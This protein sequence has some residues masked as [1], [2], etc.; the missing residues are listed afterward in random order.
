MRTTVGAPRFA[1]E[2]T[3]LGPARLITPTR[4]MLGLPQ[5]AYQLAYRRLLNATGAA[6]IHAELAGI[7]AAADAVTGR[8]S[9][10]LVLLCFDRLDK[11]GGWCHRTMFAAWWLEQTGQELPEL[12]ATLPSQPTPPT[13]F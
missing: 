12:G 5:D 9:A 8:S 13:L 7:A 4:A 6:R 10:R 3:L 11:R 2:Y 1:L